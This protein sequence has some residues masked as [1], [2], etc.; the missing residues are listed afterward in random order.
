MITLQAFVGASRK[1]LRRQRHLCLAT[2]MLL[3]TVHLVEQWAKL[4]RRS[5]AV[6]GR[7]NGVTNQD[8]SMYALSPRMMPVTGGFSS[9]AVKR[10]LVLNTRASCTEPGHLKDKSIIRNMLSSPVSNHKG[11]FITICSSVICR[12]SA[13]AFDKC[14]ESSP[15]F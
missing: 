4:K 15:A 10:G 13:S 9:K 11:T 6:V 3:S 8:L 12:E 7:S 1:P 14:H 2:P 5:A